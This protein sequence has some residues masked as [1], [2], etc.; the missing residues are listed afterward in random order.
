VGCKPHYSYGQ[1]S[2]RLQT[3]QFVLEP[4][5]L[6]LGLALGLALDFDCFVFA[7]VLPPLEK[8]KHANS[9]KCNVAA[10]SNA[11]AAPELL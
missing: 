6:P 7:M 11:F 10:L 5:I 3:Q 8:F 9:P 4:D 1:P 2:R